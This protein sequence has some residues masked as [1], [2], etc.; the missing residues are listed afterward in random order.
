MKMV[1]PC[2]RM[3][4]IRPETSYYGFGWVVEG[5]YVEDFSCEYL[6]MKLWIVMEGV[7]S[8]YESFV[9]ERDFSNASSL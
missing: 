5:C 4:E 9:Y 7:N 6:V 3:E 8:G 1:L 2:L